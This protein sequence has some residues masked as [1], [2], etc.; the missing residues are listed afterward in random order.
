MAGYS[1]QTL[2]PKKSSLARVAST[3]YP[4]S[5]AKLPYVAP[6]AQVDPIKQFAAANPAPSFSADPSTQQQF[7]YYGAA[8]S[9]GGL[10]AAAAPPAA[11]APDGTTVDYANDPILKQMQAQIASQDAAAEA[12][13]QQ[14]RNTNFIRYG[15]S[16]LARAAGADQAT[17][18]AAGANS[19][20]T[21][22]ELGRWNDRSLGNIDSVRNAQNLYYSSTR[23]RDRGLQEEDLLRQKT[24]TG[25]QLQDVLTQIAQG[26]LA[27][28]QQSQGQLLSAE[29]SAYQRALA[30][31]AARQPVAT[32]AAPA[33]GAR[34]INDL[35]GLPPAGQ[36]SQIGNMLWYPT[37]AVRPINPGSGPG[38]F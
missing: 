4:N 27:E 25:N 9:G 29:E 38:Y 20:G 2:T 8:P 14:A 10:A 26:L 36:S 1:Y 19:F 16:D 35:S 21:V 6:Q 23:A 33:G 3:V 24:T 5:A 28:R 11:V 17:I 30:A 12:A 32:A 18:D 15:S 13:A 34:S 22:E 37:G 31:A 7:S